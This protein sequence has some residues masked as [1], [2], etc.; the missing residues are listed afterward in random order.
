M[1]HKTVPLVLAILLAACAASGRRISVSDSQNIREEVVE[2][3]P[4]KRPGWYINPPDSD[5]NYDYFVGHSARFS[6]EA[7]A[8]DEAMNNAV[9]QFVR[10]CGVEVGIFDEYLKH[11]TGKTSGVLAGML[12]NKEY[13]QQ[14]AQAFVTSIRPKEWYLRKTRTY[15]DE[16]PISSGWKVSVL[17]KVPVEEKIR[18]QEYAEKKKA[19]KLKI[20][21]GAHLD[22][23]KKIEDALKPAA[24]YYKLAKEFI[25]QKEIFSAIDTLNKAEKI[26]ENLK[27]NEYFLPAKKSIQEKY[28]ENVIDLISVDKDRLVKGIVLIKETGDGQKIKPDTPLATPLTVKALCN[29]SGEEIP[30]TH[31][32]IKFTEE[33]KELD[34]TYT[35]KGG[36][37][38][39]R[40]LGTTTEG[41][42]HLRIT[43]SLDTEYRRD[44]KFYL[45]VDRPEQKPEEKLSVKASF[46]YE[47]NG[48]PKQMYEGMTLRSHVDFY[49]VYFRPEQDC[50]VY[51]YQ[52]DSTGA[53]YQ[54]FPNLTFSNS[55][56]PV[57][58]GKSYTIPG[59]DQRFYLDDVTGEERLYLLAS[60]TPAT[61][62]EN[63]FA[64][65]EAANKEQKKAIQAQIKRSIGTRGVG[66]TAPA[67]KPHTVTAKSG[68]TFDVIAKSIESNKTGFV[69]V[70][71]FNHR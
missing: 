43:A 48:V 36:K 52:V 6:T 2:S 25:T 64:R 58:K 29:L 47:D 7:A 67:S 71:S 31:A 65:L 37:A 24:D 21:Q 49:S 38:S 20:Q 10:F 41:K 57:K 46:L 15:H 11:T 23:V 19:D 59:K 26:V 40:V 70:L 55:W 69:H 62:L 45:I 9:K 3:L 12:S 39:L 54:L 14:K 61:E 42:N 1:M 50:Y 30:L 32:P 18:V 13:E 16:T 34:N 44:V 4:E 68:K 28:N 66:G 8:R 5:T 56:N 17:V 60:K 27:E 63:L 33:E 51:V 35:D 22:E 53:I